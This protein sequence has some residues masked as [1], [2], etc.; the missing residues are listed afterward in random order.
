MGKYKNILYAPFFEKNPVAVQV[1][2]ICSALAVT[3]KIETALAMA[4]AV[5]TVIAFSNLSVSIIRDHIPGS[6]RII[7]EMTIIASLVIIVDQFLKAYAYQTSK[8]M[9]VFVGLIITNCIV[10]GRAEAV[11][12][13][14]PPATS[15]VDGIGNGLGY[16][17]ML[18]SVAFFRELLGSGTLLGFTVLPLI[19]EGG[20]YMPNGLFLLAP[21]G[22]IIVG[23]LIW[24][25]RTW[26]PELREM[27]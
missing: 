7:I 10:L 24:A 2:G 22:F 21:S 19:T 25:L 6:I 14:N 3:T 4:F 26:K 5:T 18:L 13:K 1:L 16:S 27:E 15:F 23:L 8:Q 9:S 17:I 12:L 11:A 20:W